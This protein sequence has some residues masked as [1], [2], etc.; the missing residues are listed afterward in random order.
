MELFQLLRLVRAQHTKGIFWSFEQPASSYMLHTSAIKELLKLSGVKLVRLDQCCFGLRPGDYAS[1]Y[2]S[3]APAPDVRVKK[4]TLLIT[5]F[6]EV[7]H[8]ERRC[9]GATNM[10]MPLAASRIRAAARGSAPMPQA[11]RSRMPAGS[12]ATLKTRRVSGTYAKLLAS[13]FAVLRAWSLRE[14]PAQTFGDLEV[15]DQHLTEFVEAY[16]ARY[17]E[18]NERTQT[19]AISLVRHA[20]LAVQHEY[21]FVQGRLRTAWECLFTWEIEMPV[22]TRV[23]VPENLM[24]AC[25]VWCLVLGFL[26]QP[27]RAHQWITFGVGILI[28]FEGLARPGE[29]LKLR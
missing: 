3:V 14:F 8:L 4:P 15:L 18:S 6:P 29:F 23:P 24:L 21:R 20:L 5:N 11:S 26:R 9:Q 17:K 16:Y 13:A 22:R 1:Q 12:G 25:A 19:K 7:A 28:M 2:D 10:F 27:G